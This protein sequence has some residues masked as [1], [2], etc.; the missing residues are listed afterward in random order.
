[1]KKNKII[2]LFILVILNCGYAQNLKFANYLFENRAYVDA[3]KLFLQTN[4][5]TQDIYEKLADCYY[6]NTK[7]EEAA[8]WY[9]ILMEKHE[10]TVAPTYFFRYAQALQGVN[11]YD[12]AK[13][14]LTKYHSKTSEQKNVENIN[15]DALLK[16]NNHSIYSVSAIARNTEA[17]DFGGA[18]YNGKLVFASTRSGGKAYKWNNLPYLDLY[19]ADIDSLG[20]LVNIE[21]FSSAINTKL[22]ESNA[23][24]TKDGKT[25][26]FTRNNENHSSTIK[27]NKKIRRLKIYKAEFENG[28][29]GNVQELPFNSDSYSVMHPALSDDE[30]QLYF[31]SDMPGT[32]GLFDLFVVDI[33]DGDSYSL[34]KNLGA[35][36]NTEQLEQFP[37]YSN[38]TLYY[39]SNGHLGLGGLDVF[40]SANSKEGFS[41][42][43]NL[44]KDINSNLDDF[45]FVVNDS[46]SIGYVSSNRKGGQGNDDIYK[47]TKKKALLV[48]NGI[49]K[50]SKD[51]K[52]IPYAVVAVLDK[53][54]KVVKEIQAN[55]EAKFK[56]KL[57]LDT[58]YI[59]KA[60]HKH[61]VSN[62]YV[63]DSKNKE[64]PKNI[65]ILLDLYEAVDKNIVKIN[66]KVQIKHEPIYFDLNSSYLTPSAKQI[67]DDIVAVISKYP[68]MKIQCASHTDSRASHRYNQWLSDRRAKRTADYIISKGISA[69]R[70]TKQGFGETELVNKCADNVK[71]TESEHSLN[72]RSEF[73]L[74]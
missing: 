16:A 50:S 24:F 38:D 18:F 58:P 26:Y 2:F 41:I 27:S 52:P 47:F 45:G 8:K 42:P 21:P 5:K 33:N 54:N 23:V 51:L 29:W 22:H 44:N 65:E 61:Y 17:I 55:E 74:E 63:V 43:E 12:Q 67:L 15:F 25:M 31:S 59:I 19:Q 11:N 73:V 36:I 57:K 49:V 4:N 9:K 14:W 1:M 10:A 72:R 64:N 35:K 69:S 7:I 56:V 3:S 37:F 20:G 46:A 30:K 6:F 60:S 39:S 66:K 48:I 32:I 53:D 40:K 62:G 68:D 34:P 71:C 13:I 70:I 28:E